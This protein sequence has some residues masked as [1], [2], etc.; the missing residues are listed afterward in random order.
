MF[1]VSRN[2]ET[3]NTYGWGTDGTGLDTHMMKNTEWGAVAYFSQSTYG[4][5]SEIWVNPAN[6]FTT[7][8]A[9][10]SVS[11]S[12]TTGCLR[13]YDTPNGMSASTTGNTYGI[14]D[15]SGGNGEYVA[16]YINNSHGNLFTYGNNITTADS[17]YKD[18][19]TVTSDNQ[20]NN[21]NNA[22]TKKGDAVYE[23]SSSYTNSNGWNAD[24]SC[25]PN[26]EQPWFQ[27]GGEYGHTTH[28]GAFYFS[29]YT[30]VAHSNM[31]FRPVLLVGTEL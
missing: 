23:T 27:R 15:I 3:N 31:G 19:Y 4:K 11:S 13:T 29:L 25:M 21:Y 12:S 17:K 5:N 20:V 2:M 24:Y 22:S 6:D 1:T 14:Y 18:V 7:G 30:G 26:Y 16:A 28:A 10:D 8:C 9:G